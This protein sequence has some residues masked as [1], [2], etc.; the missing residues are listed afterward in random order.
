MKRSVL[1]SL[2]P[3]IDDAQGNNEPRRRISPN[4]LQDEE[5][6]QSLLAQSLLGFSS[7]RDLLLTSEQ[8][9]PPRLFPADDCSN[10]GEELPDKMLLEDFSEGIE[11]SALLSGLLQ[12]VVERELTQRRHSAQTQQ[13]NVASLLE[14]RDPEQVEAKHK[15][16]KS[17]SEIL[18]SSLDELY[19]SSGEQLEAVMLPLVSNEQMESLLLHWRQLLHTAANRDLHEEEERLLHDGLKTFQTCALQISSCP[20][21]QQVVDILTLT[22]RKSKRRDALL[23]QVF[24]SFE[25]LATQCLVPKLDVVVSI[26]RSMLSILQE[27]SAE[28]IVCKHGCAILYL[29]SVRSSAVAAI[30][31]QHNFCLLLTNILTIYQEDGN[32]V[33]LGLGI[34]GSIAIAQ[35]L[36]STYEAREIENCLLRIIRL[37]SANQMIRKLA[38]NSVWLLA[39]DRDG[40][41][42]GDFLNLYMLLVHANSSTTQTVLALLYALFA[43]LTHGKNAVKIFLERKGLLLLEYLMK[44]HVTSSQDV[45]KISLGIFI[46]CL[47]SGTP[48]I[49]ASLRRVE[50]CQVLTA[51]ILHNRAN[52]LICKYTCILLLQIIHTLDSVSGFG[53]GEALTNIVSV[54]IR[55]KEVDLSL[56]KLSVRLFMI[57]CNQTTMRAELVQYNLPILCIKAAIKYLNTDVFPPLLALITELVQIE[58]YLNSINLADLRL[59][60]NLSFK[61]FIETPELCIKTLQLLAIISEQQRVCEALV[62]KPLLLFLCALL[63]KYFSAK[64]SCLF[65]L[66]ILL[67][68]A[69]CETHRTMFSQIKLLK[70]IETMMNYYAEDLTMLGKLIVCFF[71]IWQYLEQVSAYQIEEGF[72]LISAILQRYKAEEALVA[73]ILTGLHLFCSSNTPLKIKAICSTKLIHMMVY[74]LKLHI[75]KVELVQRV[76]SLISSMLFCSDIPAITELATVLH[77]M[78]FCHFLREILLRHYQNI[79]ISKEL[80]AIISI[81]ASSD[82]LQEKMRQVALFPL[83]LQSLSTCY[84]DPVKCKNLLRTALTLF[85]YA[86]NHSTLNNDMG[87]RLLELVANTYVSEEHISQHVCNILIALLQ[88]EEAKSYFVKF[89]FTKILFRILRNHTNSIGLVKLT[90]RLIITGITSQ[91]S[92]QKFIEEN[93]FVCLLGLLKMHVGNGEVCLEICKVCNAFSPFVNT[94]DIRAG[95]MLFDLAGTIVHRNFEDPLLCKEFLK[96]LCSL[97]RKDC[98]E[99]YEKLKSLIPLWKSIT[100]KYITKSD[101]STMACL[102]L[103]NASLALSDAEALKNS[104]IID[105]MNCVADKHGLTENGA[106]FFINAFGF[107]VTR[108]KH[109]KPVLLSYGVHNRV[110]GMLKKFPEVVEIQVNGEKVFE[111]IH[112]DCD[113]ITNISSHSD[114]VELQ[115]HQPR[116]ETPHDYSKDSADFESLEKMYEREVIDLVSDE[117]DST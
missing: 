96:L 108:N 25:I 29:I 50:M 49:S 34:L 82:A 94:L 112:G 65:I 43:Y 105:C 20:L 102:L 100:E 7:F 32:I 95:C 14:K 63:R 116:V 1:L 17:R 67:N 106:L 24:L 44:G 98:S 31:D 71:K 109:F 89:N 4:N 87:W 111:R 53:L 64:D 10:N 35:R 113:G 117:E 74:V 107:I 21:L 51:C 3:D 46:R 56:L 26:V 75:N 39:L 30:L 60:V 62:D 19:V 13:G 57:L 16:K 70:A 69:S 42:N 61:Q 78:Q 83:I 84:K 66:A 15:Q 86:P 54:Y 99:Y 23:E 40:K 68:V 93:A 33:A 59:L 85:N 80:S 2:D 22:L 77:D 9:P 12:D 91:E 110:L 48:E 81:F 47:L 55:R 73:N 36:F 72:S 79:E 5:D 88:H 115:N 76:L 92:K 37:H 6:D 103:T 27:F 41:V 11:D 8:V 45:V 90:C 28:S 104:S 101:I 38:Y 18:P 52:F 97:I 114:S 58:G